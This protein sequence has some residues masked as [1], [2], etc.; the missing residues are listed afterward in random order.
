M[1][2]GKEGR[3]TGGLVHLTKTPRLELQIP[4]LPLAQKPLP[5]SSIAPSATV[6]L[7]VNKCLLSICD[8]AGGPWSRRPGRSSTSNDVA[9]ALRELTF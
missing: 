4:P 7:L 9:L 3:R 5:P 2:G 6:L 8:V 1:L